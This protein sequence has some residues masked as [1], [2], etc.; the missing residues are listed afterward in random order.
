MKE[1]IFGFLTALIVL[2]A[3]QHLWLYHKILLALSTNAA[4]GTAISAQYTESNNKTTVTA[5]T[6]SNGKAVF[7]LSGKKIPWLKIFPPK[8]IVVSTVK[9]RGWKTRKIALNEQNEYTGKPLKPRRAVDWYKLFVFGGLG[10]YLAWLFVRSLQ[11]GFPKDDPKT[12]KMIN[13]EFLRIVFTLGVVCHHSGYYLK[14]WN[15]GFLG[16]EFFFILSGFLLVF[17][18]S[19][20]KDMLTFMKNK[21]IRYMPLVIFGGILSAL[22]YKNV[23]FHYFFD[24]FLFYHHRFDFFNSHYNG[25]AW[26]VFVLFWISSLYFYLMKTQRRETVNI[27]IAVITVLSSIYVCKYGVESN[28]G[29]ISARITR[30]LACMGYG[31]LAAQAYAVLKDKNVVNQ[32]GYNAFEFFVLFMAIFGVFI[33]QVFQDYA[34]SCA[35]F[36][37]IILLFAL[38]KG[39]VSNF[40]EKPVFAKAARYCLAVYLT[41][42]VIANDVLNMYSATHKAMI[43]AHPMIIN[44]V[45][46]I[47]AVLLGV[48]AHHAIELPATRALKKWL[49]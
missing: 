18:F 4:P 8:G 29:I 25:P 36:T 7:E 35:C 49:G 24:S 43:L 12:P 41:H 38:R 21:W 39:A 46:L 42:M 40:F 31:Y 17:T 10:Y 26:F 32:K 27:I 48:I 37:M 1:K 5:Q 20:E 34:F 45:V 19:P 13:I 2:A 11:D 15:A 47:S 44:F 22:T 33:R 28:T 3:T 9:I 14:I 30:G 16:V 6:D 23:E